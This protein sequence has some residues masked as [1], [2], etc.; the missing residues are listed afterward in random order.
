MV[1]SA[2][3]RFLAPVGVVSREGQAEQVG[4]VKGMGVSGTH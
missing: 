2:H 1:G 3:P 4:T